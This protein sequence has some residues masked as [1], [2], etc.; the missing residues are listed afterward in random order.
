M[1][2]GAAPVPSVCLKLNGRLLDAQQ[3]VSKVSLNSY[4][5]VKQLLASFAGSPFVA[6]IQ[7][8][9]FDNSQPGL[10]RFDVTLVVNPQ[11]PL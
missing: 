10:L 8:E 5:R 1:A 4:R 3:P 6:A 11:H 2:G 7:N 9:H